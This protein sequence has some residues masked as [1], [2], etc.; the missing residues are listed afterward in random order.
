MPS[1]LSLWYQLDSGNL[2]RARWLTTA[3]L[4]ESD[5]PVDSGYRYGNTTHA[6]W[7]THEADPLGAFEKG[8]PLTSFVFGRSA[9]GNVTGLPTLIECLMSGSS[10]VITTEWYL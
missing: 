9:H 7:N 3:Q 4:E 2:A 5:T 10:G 6:G 8:A 1:Q